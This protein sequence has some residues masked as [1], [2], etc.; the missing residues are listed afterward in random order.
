[1]GQSVQRGLRTAENTG[2]SSLS[3]CPRQAEGRGTS[4]TTGKSHKPHKQKA[5]VTGGRGVGTQRV[6]GEL[7]VLVPV[8]GKSSFLNCGSVVLQAASIVS[9][10]HR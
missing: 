8:L 10:I 4:S 7:A 9:S 2:I 5:G 1:M 3:S 6:T